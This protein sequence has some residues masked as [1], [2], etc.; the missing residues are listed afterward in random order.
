[1]TTTQTYIASLNTA[2]AARASYETEKNSAND[3]IQ[4][5]LTSLHKAFNRAEVIA[6]IMIDSSV[7]AEFINRQERSNNRYNVYAAQ[8][9]ENAVSAA[10][11]SEALNHYSLA[12]LRAVC[13]LHTIT[14]KDAVSLCSESVKHSDA[15]R[16][17]AIKSLRYAKHVAATTASTQS[18]SSLNALLT[19][20]ILCESR[21]A[22][23]DVTYTLNSES[24]M[25]KLLA[26][27]E[28]YSEMLAI[29]ASE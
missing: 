13:K 11:A 8:K 18:S 26:A 24:A 25:F 23:N 5:V 4:S 27:Q 7:N 2:I 10:S 9:V 12:I 6:Q 19:C 16:E 15:K 22:E 17:R 14:H 1:M 21:N 3:S 28:R 29:A 20:N